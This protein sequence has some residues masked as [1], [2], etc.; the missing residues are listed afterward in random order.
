MMNKEIHLPSMDILGTAV[1]IRQLLAQAIN[2]WQ[3]LQVA[4]DSAEAVLEVLADIYVQLSN[5][6]DIVRDIERQPELRTSEIYAQLSITSSIVAEVCQQLEVMTKLQQKSVSTLSTK[7]LPQG[8]RDEAKLADILK[9]LEHAK[10]E[11]VLATNLVHLSITADEIWT[12]LQSPETINNDQ[13]RE[14]NG[15]DLMMQDAMRDGD[16]VDDIMGL[17]GSSRSNNARIK[18][19]VAH[20]GQRNASGGKE[21]LNFILNS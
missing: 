21:W 16:Q 15:Y 20:G 3:Q 11:L 12:S 18:G 4:L 6:L 17:E 10:A 14:S 7:P 13:T 2:L 19:N 8:P 9:Q 1:T 5:L